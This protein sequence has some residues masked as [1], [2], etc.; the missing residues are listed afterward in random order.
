MLSLISAH[1]ART[2][3]WS[4]RAYPQRPFSI[5]RMIVPII[6]PFQLKLRYMMAP[7]RPFHIFHFL[8]PGT[9]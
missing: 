6:F 7:Q 1:P 8:T 2:N 3:T 4:G 5:P 9:G